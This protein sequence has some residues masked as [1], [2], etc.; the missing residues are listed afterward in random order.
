MPNKTLHFKGDACVRGK[1]SKQRITALVR[2]NIDESENFKFLV[3][4][5]FKNL[6]CFT[7]IK[8]LPVD[9]V[10][11]TKAWMTQDIFSKRNR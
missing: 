10:F 5:K 6:R 9:Y 1:S 3:I 2:A 4:G 11:N 8:T 7:G